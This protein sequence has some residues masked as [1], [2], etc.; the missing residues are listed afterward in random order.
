[1][2]PQRGNEFRLETYERIAIITKAR[3][4]T[5]KKAVETLNNQTEHLTCVQ[6]KTLSTYLT[7]V[8][9]KK[10][11]FEGNFQR[12]INQTTSEVSLDSLITDQN[13]ITE[14]YTY[15][16]SHIESL[17]VIDNNK[18]NSDADVNTSTFSQNSSQVRLP[19]INLPK[20]SGDLLTWSS[21]INLYDATI[22]NNHLLT[23][24]TRFQYLLGTLE[25]NH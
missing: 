3:F 2:A 10:E 8:Q 19:K 9:R 1:M 4:E 21:F 11:D 24:V 17:I 5:I 6:E 20:F 12:I 13:D 7:E 14:L 18:T 25:E 23:N 15:I 16:V 22:H